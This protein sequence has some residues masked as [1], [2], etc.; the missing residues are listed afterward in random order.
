M[1]CAAHQRVNQHIAVRITRAQGATG[2]RAFGDR[3]VA[4]REQR[5]IIHRCQ[6]D[7]DRARSGV[8]QAVVGFHREAVR[9]DKSDR[10][11]TRRRV[12]KRAVGIEGQY[13]VR[14]TTD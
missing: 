7:R 2:G 1:G 8:C 14:R 13:A 5:R 3:Y 12:G 6:R 9:R 4:C 10:R 11:L